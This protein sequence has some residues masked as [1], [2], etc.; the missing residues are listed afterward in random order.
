M[1]A[2]TILTP[3][4][5][6][7]AAGLAELAERWRRQGDEI[8]LVPTM[9]A[10]HEGHLSLVRAARNA[11][12][13][14]IVSIFVNPTQFGPHE[15]L[16]KYPRTL[17]HDLELLRPLGVDAIFTPDENELYPPGFSTFVQPPDLSVLWEGAIRS[18]HFR[19]VTTIVLKLLLL[20]RA[21]ITFFGQKD[22][23]QAAVVRRMLIDLNVGCALRVLPTVRE[24]D[25]LAMSSRNRYLSADD[26]RRATALY[27]VLT[28]AQQALASGERDGHA[29][30]A[31]MNQALID[32]GF[33]SVD[34]AVAC[35]PETLQ[36]A[37]PIRLP[38]VLLVAAR[39]GG[40]R[41][42]DN[43]LFEGP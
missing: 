25:G 24:P 34:Y 1:G 33:D 22:F 28:N 2:N 36:M 7:Q 3:A 4:I 39:I 37:D 42:I 17:D 38:V 14:V 8:A 23:Q 6:N 32:A 43:L 27:R 15:D 31:E 12:G 21:T 18:T 5:I 16:A 20:S 11:A 13:R 29:L 9:G 35:D 41:L 10:L 40:T 30:A 26:R 19:G